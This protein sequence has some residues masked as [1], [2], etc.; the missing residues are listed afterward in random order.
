MVINSLMWIHAPIIYKFEVIRIL[1]LRFARH[2]FKCLVQSTQTRTCECPA[3]SMMVCTC[4]YTYIRV[5]T[6]VYI[7]ICIYTRVCIYIYLYAHAIQMKSTHVCKLCVYTYVHMYICIHAY[8]HTTIVSW[9]RYFP[10]KT[11][12]SRFLPGLRRTL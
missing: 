2:I 12:L 1:I 5:Y 6:H 11:S 8:M 3:P 4:T 9:P 10:K 7:Y